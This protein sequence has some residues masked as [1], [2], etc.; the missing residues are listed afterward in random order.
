[1]ENENKRRKW[2]L[3]GPEDEDAHIEGIFEEE[4][5]DIKK[6]CQEATTKRK[7]DHDDIR[8]AHKDKART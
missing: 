8:K 4:I 5:V 7:S 1:M 2:R 3:C 6:K